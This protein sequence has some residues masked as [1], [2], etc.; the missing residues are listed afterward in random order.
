MKAQP[1]QI[2]PHF[3]RSA[4]C[5][6]RAVRTRFFAP[7]FNRRDAKNAERKCRLHISALFAPLRF[8]RCSGLVA[9]RLPCVSAFLA[10]LR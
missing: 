8:A 5:K 3:P 2:T 4:I 10:S 6:N 7:K 9:A 1:N